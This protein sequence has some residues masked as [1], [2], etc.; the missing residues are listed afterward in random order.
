MWIVKVKS[1]KKTQLGNNLRIPLLIFKRI[2][3]LI[4]FDFLTF[5]QF[6]CKY[7]DPACELSAGPLSG[8]SASSP[9]LGSRWLLARTSDADS[10]SDSHIWMQ[11]MSFFFSCFE[12]KAFPF[13]ASRF[14]F[15]FSHV[16]N[17]KNGVFDQKMQFSTVNMHSS[18]V[19][20]KHDSNQWEQFWKLSFVM[21]RLK[22]RVLEEKK[23]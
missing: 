15:L 13:F 10:C 7:R 5:F 3:V 12:C 6:S 20:R 11:E 23:Y 22:L 18:G 21:L 2:S 9:D 4:C 19:R 1:W 16:L 8:T 14:L 17:A